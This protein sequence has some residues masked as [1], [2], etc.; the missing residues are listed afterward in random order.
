[1]LRKKSILLSRRR[2]GRI[3][4][5]NRLVSKYTREKY[6]INTEKS[7][8]ATASNHLNRQFTAGQQRKVFVTDLNY[9]RVKQH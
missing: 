3:M 9:V 8:E 4:Q 1:V 5:E 2:I 7:N 6:R